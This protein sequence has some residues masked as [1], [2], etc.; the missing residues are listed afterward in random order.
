M[1]ERSELPQRGLGRSP[2]EKTKLGHFKRHRT[3]LVAIYRKLW[4][5]CLTSWKAICHVYQLFTSFT[6]KLSPYCFSCSM[7]I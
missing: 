6:K 1:E 3:L 5:P 4:K 7:F 2:R